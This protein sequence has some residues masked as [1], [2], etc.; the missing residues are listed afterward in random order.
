MLVAS[1][2]GR[3]LRRWSGPG[4]YSHLTPFNLPTAPLSTLK[5]TPQIRK[6][7]PQ[8][9]TSLPVTQQVRVVLRPEPQS[10]TQTRVLSAASG[11]KGKGGIWAE[12]ACGSGV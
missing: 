5:P 12:A 6:L 11:R 9:E 10:D 1:R 2:R 8:E 7:A 4:L 3:P